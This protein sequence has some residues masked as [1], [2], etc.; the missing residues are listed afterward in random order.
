MLWIITIC[1]VV[2][3]VALLPSALSVNLAVLQFIFPDGESFRRDMIFF[4]KLLC[5]MGFLTLCIFRGDG[6]PYQ[7]FVG[8]LVFLAVTGLILRSTKRGQVGL[9][10]YI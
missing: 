1:L 8:G 4:L 3:A 6:G 7:G 2:I 9:Q 10:R 5:I